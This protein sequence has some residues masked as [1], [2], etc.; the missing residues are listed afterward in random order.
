MPLLTGTA[1]RG[2]CRAVLGAAA[3]FGV[4]I[5]ASW[6]QQPSPAEIVAL[7]FPREWGPAPAL[8]LLAEQ[9][10][11]FE[12]STVS[13]PGFS[14]YSALTLPGLPYPL[15]DVAKQ[16]RPHA[17]P[18]VNRNALFNDA[19]IAGIKERLNLTR[20]QERY[21]PAVEQALRG[22]VF[23]KNRDGA[24]VLDPDSVERL[25]IAARELIK[26]LNE[27]QKREV[28]TLAHLVGLKN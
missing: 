23:R 13:N 9:G 1:G 18:S 5:G 4:L 17:D 27:T 26:K 25:N 22:I 15:T 19:Q 10:R 16:T 21:W 11:A 14:S 12:K 7:R 20:E 6:A 24:H 3:S 28:Q 2:T 8:P